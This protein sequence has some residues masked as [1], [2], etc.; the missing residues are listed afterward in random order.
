MH[1]N[2]Q[3]SQTPLTLNPYDPDNICPENS[4]CFFT[5]VAY[6]RVHLRLDFIMEANNKNQPDL[7][8]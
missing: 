7:V 3:Y 6:I 4:V 1:E 2:H 8:S 5:S